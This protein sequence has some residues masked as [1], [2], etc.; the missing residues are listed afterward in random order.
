M[1]SALLNV[2][3]MVAVCVPAEEPSA[4]A[5]I[6]TGCGIDQFWGVKTAAAGTMFKDG[7]GAIDGDIGHGL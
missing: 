6:V 7:G 2:C 1:A 4:T 5:V 3:V